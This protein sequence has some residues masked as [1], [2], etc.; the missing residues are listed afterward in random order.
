VTEPLRRLW[1]DQAE[2]WA[3]WARAPDHD[4][5]WHFTR[6]RLFEILP[7]P[8]ELTVDLGGGEGRLARELTARGH[9]VVG[10]DSSETLVHLA[11]THD[12]AAAAAVGDLAALPVA[13]EAADLAVACMSLQDVDDLDGAVREAARV[14]R[15]GGHLALVIV[16]PIN[17]AGHFADDSAGTP[18][19]I[20]SPYL[21]EF[22]YSDHLERDGLEMTFHSVHRPLET[23]AQALHDAGFLIETIREPA[24]DSP[25]GVTR[26]TGWDRIP[27]FCF[28]R[29][30]KP[31]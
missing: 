19:V 20:D 22:R 4:T 13:A 9:R 29:A 1:D 6:W 10:I 28:I 26:F 21:S 14:L 23:Y 18:F 2:A 17:S 12:E 5:F 7:E 11:V 16:H 30:L 3:A 15:P 31:R 25:A 8:G 24:W 27:I